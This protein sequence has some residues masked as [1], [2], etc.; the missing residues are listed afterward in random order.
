MARTKSTTRKIGAEIPPPSTRSAQARASRELSLAPEQ[1]PPPPTTLARPTRS[2]GKRPITQK[3]PPPPSRSYRG[4]GY[5]FLLR[6]KLLLLYKIFYD[7]FPKENFNKNRFTMLRNYLFWKHVVINRPLC[8]T[9]LANLTILKEKYLDFTEM[10]EFQRWMP[11]FELKGH[12]Y[13]DLLHRIVNHIILPQNGS[14]RRVSFC[15][16]LVLFALIMRVKIS[17]A[18]L[19]MRHMHDCIKSDRNAALPYGMFLTKVFEAYFVNL[20]NESYEDKKSYLKGGGAVKRTVKI[21]I[22]AEKGKMEEQEEEE[23]RSR[24]SGS[25]GRNPK[26][27]WIKLLITIVRELIQEV[28]NVV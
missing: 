10:I 8:A 28:I 12:V 7:D 1:P 27:I 4:C 21:D 25:R 5:C 26:G 3:T 18:Y 14:Y 17:F 15:D 13:P 6:V 2:R 9:F 11:L 24:A 19:I 16:T 20:D 23:I 22:R